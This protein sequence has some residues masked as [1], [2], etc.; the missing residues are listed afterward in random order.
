MR[1]IVKLFENGSVCVVGLRGRGKDMLFG[2]VIARR[3]I[4]YVSNT[5]YGGKHI[6]FVPSAYNCGGNT[7]RNFIS[8]VIKPYQ[9]PHPD[10]TDIYVADCGVYFPSQYCNELNRDYAYLATYSALSRHLGQSSMHVNCQNLNRVYDK[11]REMSDTYLLCNWCKVFFK[12]RLV[13]Q[14]ITI[15]DKYQ[16]CVD[17]VPMFWLRRPLLDANRLQLWQIQKQNYEITHGKIKSRILLYRNK[18]EYNTRVF[19]EMMEPCVK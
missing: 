17:R 8:G 4:P 10:G 5:N 19:K 9:F 6:P 16:S 18:A 1:K 14:K 3:K 2:N 11:L 13:L 12:G 15:Y 7:Y